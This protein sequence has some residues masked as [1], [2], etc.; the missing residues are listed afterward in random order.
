MQHWSITSPGRASFLFIAHTPYYQTIFIFSSVSCF[1]FLGPWTNYKQGL[2]EMTFL[3]YDY[4]SEFHQAS[5][6]SSY[7]WWNPSRMNALQTENVSPLQQ[8]CKKNIKKKRIR[9]KTDF[10]RILYV[11]WPLFI[12]YSRMN[13]RITLFWHNIHPNGYQGKCMG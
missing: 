2:M 1:Y 13:P 6:I 7:P 10:Y 8:H 12:S 4:K 11:P 5:S 3:S 9:R